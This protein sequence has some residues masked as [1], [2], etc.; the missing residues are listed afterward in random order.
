MVMSVW[1]ELRQLPAMA[2]T[3]DI[4]SFPRPESIAAPREVDSKLAGFWI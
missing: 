3:D 2:S 4:V 1:N